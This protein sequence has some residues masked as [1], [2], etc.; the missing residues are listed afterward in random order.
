MHILNRV[1]VDSD[2]T[3][4]VKAVKTIPFAYSEKA[5]TRLPQPIQADNSCKVGSLDEDI[6]I[7]LPSSG[8]DGSS[9]FSPEQIPNP[10][11]GTYS[12]TTSGE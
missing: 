9:N 10:A 3:P 7:R 5:S 4:D 2:K 8:D 6:R 12:R 1:Q 11:G